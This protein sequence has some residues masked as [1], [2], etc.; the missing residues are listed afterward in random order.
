MKFRLLDEPPQ[1]TEGGWVRI[2]D[3]RNF[4]ISTQVTAALVEVEPDH[5]REIHWH[6]DT[7]EWQYYIMGKPA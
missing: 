2:A 7:D 5:M 3:T 6:P 4:P 1:K